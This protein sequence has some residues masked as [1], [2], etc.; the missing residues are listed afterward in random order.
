LSGNV[1][2]AV[3]EDVEDG[4]D[5]NNRIR[6][7]GTQFLLV[8]E[9]ASWGFHRVDALT[10]LIQQGVRLGIELEYLLNPCALVIYQVQLSDSLRQCCIVTLHP[11]DYAPL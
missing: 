9:R 7:F 8:K 1:T 3:A 2:R 10:L 5:S 4:A 11:F 6:G